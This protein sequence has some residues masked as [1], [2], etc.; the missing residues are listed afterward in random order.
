MEPLSTLVGAVRSDYRCNRRDWTKPGFRALAVYRFGAWRRT[1]E[2]RWVRVP[3]FAVYRTLHRFVRNH[4]GIEIHETATIGPR[5]W[6]AHQGGIVIH[7]YAR[8]GSDCMIR[9]NVTIGAATFDDRHNGP[10]LG[11]RVRVGA[12]AAIIGQ[13]TI[14]DDVRIGPNAVVMRDVPAGMVVSGPPAKA[15]KMPGGPDGD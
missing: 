14:G 12:G 11:D 8:I 15:M 10:I 1:A 6:I 4:Y 7:P 3:L 13:I 2:S 5:F 9:Q